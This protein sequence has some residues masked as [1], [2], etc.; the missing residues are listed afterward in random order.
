MVLN[1]P[2]L[3]IARFCAVWSGPCQMMGPIYQEMFDRY[4]TEASFYK[5]DVDEVPLLKN[6]LGVIELPTLFFYKNGRVIEIL[7][8]MIT[9]EFL[10]E[11]IEKALNQ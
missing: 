3:Q 1:S 2:G 10:V 4:H 7:T 9:R 6:Q 8:G 11:K 5:I